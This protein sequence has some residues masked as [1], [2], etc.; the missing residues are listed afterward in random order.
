METVTGAAV[1]QSEGVA[2]HVFAVVSLKIILAAGFTVHVHIRIDVRRRD[3]FIAATPVTA[4]FHQQT[5]AGDFADLHGGRN[6]EIRDLVPGAYH[7]QGGQAYEQTKGTH[8][9][10][11]EQTHVHP[12]IMR[13]ERRDD[14]L[15]FV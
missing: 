7:E 9:A 15:V 3:G 8:P 4:R 12:A 6:R 2:V 13:R 5:L 14:L 10:I 1:M 11:E